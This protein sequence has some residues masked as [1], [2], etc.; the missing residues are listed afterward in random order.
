MPID[1]GLIGGIHVSRLARSEA[2]AD[3]PDDHAAFQASTVAALI[4]G[5][6]RGDLTIAELLQH[7][8]L[9][10]GTVDLLDGEL[11]IVDGVAWVARSD[12]RVEQVDDATTTPFAV[13]CRF[14]ADQSGPLRPA[15]SF[16]GVA[17]QIDALA[18]PR[19][20]CLAVRITAAVTYARL[21]SV[22]PQRQASPT[23]AEAIA[24][25][26]IFEA[27]TINATIVGFRFPVD[28]EGLE[29]PGWHLHLLADDRS[30]GGHVLDLAVSSGQIEIEHEDDLH[31]EIPAGVDMGTIGHDP[32][33]AAYLRRVERDN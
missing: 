31:V 1:D 25:Q 27:R 33:R 8:D 13:T 22:P 5:N 24:A 29:I 9:G 14:T 16:A 4:N 18:P 7:G 15:T 3:H 12:G 30:I 26:T 23:L 19:T 10:L 2:Q 17:A 32:Q 20:A 11:M 6:L 28:A 21:R